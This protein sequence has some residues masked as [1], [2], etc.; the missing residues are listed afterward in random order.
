M[1]HTRWG[2]IEECA[3]PLISVRRLSVNRHTS[4]HDKV[5]VS[6]N[7]VPTIVA[8]STAAAI[9]AAIGRAITDTSTRKQRCGENHR[10]GPEQYDERHDAAGARIHATSLGNRFEPAG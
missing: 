8:V 1:T 2:S 9:T 5:R 10:Q 4:R 7:A 6:A 3:M